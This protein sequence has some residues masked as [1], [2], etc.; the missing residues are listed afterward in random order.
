MWDSVSF[1]KAHARKACLNALST[2]P[3]TP[4]DIASTAGMNLS[5]VSRALRELAE[6]R[7][8]ECLTPNMTKN[9]I[10]QIT[11]EGKEV[12]QKLTTLEE[13]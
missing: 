13:H 8:V 2:G 1:A 6:K 7:L 4:S 9:K 11:N 5:H 3:K 12:L 10:Y